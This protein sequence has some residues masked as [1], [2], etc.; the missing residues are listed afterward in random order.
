M[1]IRAFP[2]SSLLAEIL[3]TVRALFSENTSPGILGGSKPQTKD[4]FQKDSR[5]EGMVKEIWI[6]RCRRNYK[7]K[8]K[9]RKIPMT[10]LPSR[11]LNSFKKN[12][13]FWES[14][15]RRSREKGTEDLN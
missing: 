10:L 5:G 13:Y 11:I 7:R 14:T 8:T 12:I 3:V 9:R 1:G 4:P 2:F 6:F 15:N